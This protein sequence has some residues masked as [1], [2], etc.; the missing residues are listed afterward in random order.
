M[1]VGSYHVIVE[2]GVDYDMANPLDNLSDGQKVRLASLKSEIRLDKITVSFSIEDRDQTGRKRACFVSET[3]SRGHGSDTE[4]VGWTVDEANLVHDIL[5]KHVVA[6]TYRDAVYRNVL[7]AGTTR[8]EVL[9]VMH[10]YDES[11]ARA[12]N[13]KGVG[14]GS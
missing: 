9:G 5:A 1:F 2:V 12:L 11:I 10:K 3:A 6:L 14:N 7:D 8:D 4:S 13:G